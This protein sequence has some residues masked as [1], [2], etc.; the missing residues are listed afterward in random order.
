MPRTHCLDVCKA[1]NMALENALFACCMLPV[2]E[3]LFSKGIL[4][5]T[6]SNTQV[7]AWEA[8][9]A[10]LSTEYSNQL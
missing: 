8:K 9:V 1:A 7:V 5:S 2:P 10:S 4:C 3:A 6:T